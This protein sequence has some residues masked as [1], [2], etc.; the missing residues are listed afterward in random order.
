MTKHKLL[1]A[2]LLCAA[3]A[4]GMT[5]CDK[6]EIY[7]GGAD[8][9]VL[10]SPAG[11]VV[12]VTDNNGRS[13][14]GYVEFSGSYV[15]N[16][17]LKT[18]K[19]VQ[20]TVTAT[21]TYDADVLKTYNEGSE[22]EVPAFPQGNVA[23]ANGGKLSLTEG[24]LESGALAVS[25]TANA[26]LNPTETY[27]VPLKVTVENG[28]LAQGATSYV[29]LVRDC[30]SFP[31]TEKSYDGKPGMKIVGVFEVNDH[32]P[33]NALGFTMKGS[34][35]QF[36]DMVVLFSANININSKTGRVYV[37]RNE[38]VQALLDNREKY[39]KPLQ[40]RGIKVILGILGNHDASGIGTLTPE[41]SK[42]FAQEVKNVCD[43][44]EL[45]GVFLDDEYTDYDAAASGKY[46]GFQ[47]SSVEA[48]SRMAYDIKQAQPQRL[49][50]SYKYQALRSAVPIEGVEPGR[51]FDYV[52][53][54]YWDT[55]D[56]VDSY[57]GLKQ[58][59]AGTGSWNCSDWSQCIPANDEWT[60]RFSLTGMREKGYGAMMIYNF[61][62]NPDF[63]M[64]KHIVNDMR[65]TARD[66]WGGELEYDNSWYPKDY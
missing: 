4:V 18:T 53:N 51:F 24:H 37:S 29:I 7:L 59:Q 44:Y 43:A 50:I 61:N 14:V 25:L 19:A 20:G 49:V 31:G 45:D 13:D 60:A 42:K 47:A 58:S 17:F 57:P 10:D 23:L 2:A 32:N 34:G 63:W 21:F 16:L 36:F 27:A 3:V 38:N 41:V 54:D 1:S 46:A 39:I 66:F 22:T 30:T 26:S 55:T 6:N 11:N 40:E 12:Y 9:G 52:L 28:Q 56:P 8:T 62:C 48:A 33:L 65:Q 15:Y 64:T 5:S 35:K